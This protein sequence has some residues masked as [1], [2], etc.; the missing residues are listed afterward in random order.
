MPILL[1]NDTGAV[2]HLTLNAPDSLNALSTAMLS[3]C[4]V[5]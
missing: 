2:A 3:R 5:H 4:L 1:R